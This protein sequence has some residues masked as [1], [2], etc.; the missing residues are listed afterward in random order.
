MARSTN[1]HAQEAQVADGASRLAGIHVL[2]VDDDEDARGLFAT[3][4]HHSGATV[5]TADS[6]RA[7]L[8]AMRL[9]QPDVLLADISMPE[10]DGYDLIA[11]VR[12]AHGPRP[13]A[14]AVSAHARKEDRERA[15]AAG[16][17]DYVTKP[18]DPAHLAAVIARLL[19]R[20]RRA[21]LVASA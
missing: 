19:G 14:I 11:A 5:A 17:D 12:M 9:A 16:Y 18:V 13:T 15:L 10:R 7:A 8:E 2:V 20:G 1:G 3:A 6:T 21:P 4:L